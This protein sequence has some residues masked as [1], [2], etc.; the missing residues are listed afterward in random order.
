MKRYFQVAREAVAY[1]V[2][3]TDLQ[4]LLAVLIGNRATPEMCGKLSAIGIRELADMSVSDLVQEGLTEREA[5]RVVAAFGLARKLASSQKGQ[6]YIVRTP[7]D[8]ARYMMEAMRYLP[9]EHFVVMH[10][11]TKNQVV[12][13]DTVFIGSLNASVAHP[14]EIFRA[15]IKRNSAAI[16]CFHNH[17]SGDP[18]PSPEDA[19][20]TRRL[21][22]TGRIMGIEVLDHI[23]IGDG[24]FISMKMR[25]MI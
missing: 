5:E 20:I 11:D 8:A 18:T 2:S 4:H 24:T 19:D 23:I 7:E 1:Y 15:A 13:H 21:V 25:G 10:L 3:D 22:E 16:I 17:P 14:R 12:A 6:P 9:Q